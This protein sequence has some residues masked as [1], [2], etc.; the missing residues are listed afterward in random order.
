MMKLKRLILHLKLWNKSLRLSFEEEKKEENEESERK[1]R[2]RKRVRGE[3]EELMQTHYFLKQS[4][5]YVQL[6]FLLL[7]RVNVHDMGDAPL[8]ILIFLSS[9]SLSWLLLR[10]RERER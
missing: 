1:K 10:E 5:I 4:N 7:Y 2:R 3:R 6:F 8:F 9:L